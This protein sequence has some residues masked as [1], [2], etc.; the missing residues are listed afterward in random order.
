MIGTVVHIA[1]GE[2]PGRKFAFL[3][4]EELRRRV[5][6]HWCKFRGGLKPEIGQIVEFE[7]APGKPGLPDRAI[8]V[9]PVGNDAG[10]DALK[11]GV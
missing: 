8:N 10:A 5:F 11:A 3:Y 1:Q 2:H 6:F 4:C 9:L 7:L